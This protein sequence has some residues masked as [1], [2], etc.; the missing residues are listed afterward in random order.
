MSDPS[1]TALEKAIL[2]LMRPLAKLALRRGMAVGE[3]IALLKQAYVESARHDFGVEGRKQTVSR[4]SLL[5]G[6][7]RK[8]VARRL[9]EGEPADTWRDRARVNRAAR[10]VSA[11]VQDADFHDRRGAPAS[12]PIESAQGPSFT[13][14]VKRHGADVTPRAVLD[15][16]SRVGAVDRLKDGR[17]RL[18]GRAYVP[19]GDESE[20]LA[21]LGTDVADLISAIGHNITEKDSE[22]FFQQKVAYDNLPIEFLPKLRDIVRRDADKLLSRLDIQM[23][24]EDRDVAIGAKSPGGHR[25]MV[26]VYYFE[27]ESHEDESAD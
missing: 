22:P 12:L 14:L 3:M 17:I 10:V 5:T 24:R 26:G 13:E 7:T 8:E 21:I 20:K 19:E 6:M 16:L 27:D 11:W 9:S 4:I 23:A 25:A 2:T 18:V 15:E 1:R